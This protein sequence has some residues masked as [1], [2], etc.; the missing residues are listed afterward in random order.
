MGEPEFQLVLQLPASSLE[1]YDEL[2]A[3]EEAMTGTFA[4]LPH[5]VDGHDFGSGMMNIF[6]HTDD[7]KEAFRLALGHFSKIEQD[8]LKAA[9]RRFN[10]D[11]YLS[12][13]PSG[14]TEPFICG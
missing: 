6:V 1:D 11:S 5:Q 10:E 2:V 8:V 3:L 7:P 14:T 13:W 4:R 9:Y 12:L